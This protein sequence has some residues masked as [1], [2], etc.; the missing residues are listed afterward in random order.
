LNVFIVVKRGKN[1]NMAEDELQ[2][3]EIKRLDSE[4]KEIENIE[5]PQKIDILTY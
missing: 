5:L 2:E 3:I 4:T 1:L